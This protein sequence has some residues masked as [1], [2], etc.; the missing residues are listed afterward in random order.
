MIKQGTRVA[1]LVTMLS[2]LLPIDSAAQS[3]VAAVLPSSRSVR[4]GTTATAFATVINTG[5]TP[6]TACGI[7][8]LT[9]IPATFS[10]QAT[11]P[12]TN[13]PIGIPNSPINIS[14][15]A[16]QTFLLSITPSAPFGAT[17]IEFS[18]ACSNAP[19][20]TPIRGLNTLLLSASPTPVPDIVALV[21]TLTNDGIANIDPD[22]R[23]GVFS[24]ATVNV[25]TSGLITASADTGGANI[26]IRTTICQTSPSTGTCLAPPGPTTATQINANATA[27]FGVF[28]QAQRPVPFDPAVSRVFVRFRDASGSVRGSTS[29]AVRDPASG[30]PASIPSDLAVYAITITGTTF[31]GSTSVLLPTTTFTPLENFQRAGCLIDLFFY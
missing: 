20:A 14:A 24:V 26:S 11:N 29:V 1:V 5:G 27:T 23:L 8:P 16:P 3:L 31:S 9:R 28:L 25:G 10:F 19:A 22:S 13:Q 2:L 17:E 15:N 6:A 21:A 30:S 7:A 4:I 12:S 18:F